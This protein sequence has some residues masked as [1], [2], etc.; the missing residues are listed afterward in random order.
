MCAAL[1]LTRPRSDEGSVLAVDVD[2]FNRRFDYR[3]LD[4]LGRYHIAKLNFCIHFK[5][6]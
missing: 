4:L 3:L 5:L 1:D 2:L 6:A